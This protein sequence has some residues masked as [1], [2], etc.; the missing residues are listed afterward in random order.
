MGVNVNSVETIVLNNSSAA[1]ESLYIHNKVLK[2]RL[3]GFRWIRNYINFLRHSTNTLINKLFL[4]EY[5]SLVLV[6]MAIMGEYYFTAQNGTVTSS[7]ALSNLYNGS[8]N[9]DNLP[10]LEVIICQM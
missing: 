4:K 6:G 1:D 8:V 7:E 9:A 10:F 3:Y 5:C 2:R